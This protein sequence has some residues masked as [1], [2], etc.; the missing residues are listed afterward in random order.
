MKVP[1]EI[2]TQIRE[3]QG[4]QS[5][6]AS[7]IPSVHSTSKQLKSMKRIATT[8]VSPCSETPSKKLR[9]NNVTNFSETAE[10]P[11]TNSTY[12]TTSEKR[13]DSVEVHHLS[14]EEVIQKLNSKN[15]LA[16]KKRIIAKLKTSLRKNLEKNNAI[17]AFLYDLT[18]AELEE[19][20]G[21]IKVKYDHGRPRL[22]S[23]VAAYFFK[24]H[25]AAPLSTLKKFKSVKIDAPRIKLVD[26]D[27]F[28]VK[29]LK[30]S[31]DC[32]IISWT[33]QLGKK[34]VQKC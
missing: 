22:Q 13:L 23:M 33:K 4:Y 12:T 3:E 10:I 31:S 32:D 19:I 2:P 26:K 7:F 27:D 29:F 17:H 8:T 1:Q 30:T 9:V 16:G 14:R 24:N 6:S 34:K 11:K 25:S 18:I 21:K 20:G 15:I 5:T 28:I